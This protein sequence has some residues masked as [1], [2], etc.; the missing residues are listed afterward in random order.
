LTSAR[1]SRG[2]RAEQLA[3]ELLEARGLR[4]LHQNWRRPEAEL[5]L[6]A[7][8]HGVCVFVEVR[9]RTGEE[10]GHALETIGPTKRARI[11][12]AARLFLSEEAVDAPGGYR[13]D[14]VAVTFAPGDDEAV[15][16]TVYVA[17]AFR[18]DG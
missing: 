8:D 13:F 6:V 7:D 14:V 4:V 1:L 18:L 16:E 12:R 17:D 15:V 3:V 5:D 2:R 9:S 10:R 11:A